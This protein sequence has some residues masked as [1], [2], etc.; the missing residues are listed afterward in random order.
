M[1]PRQHGFTLL[2]ILVAMAVLAIALAA[3]VGSTSQ[4]VNNL[5]RLYERT[6]A[7]WVAMNQI[8]A[9]QL[10]GEWP[11]VG[12]REGDI[13]MAKREWHWRITISNTDDDSIRRLDIDVSGQADAEPVSHLIAYLGRPPA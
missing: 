3:V 5:N 7:E 6:V 2:E 12:T 11:A 4:H 13:E 9:W 1:R 8:T 10:Q